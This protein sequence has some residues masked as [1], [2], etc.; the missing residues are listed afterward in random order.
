MVNVEDKV[1]LKSDA[2]IT[3]IVETIYNAGNGRQ[4]LVRVG[5]GS[6]HKIYEEDVTVITNPDIITIS[7]E[8]FQNAVCNV[9]DPKTYEGHFSDPNYPALLCA[10]GVIICE[11]LKKELFGETADNG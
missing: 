8:D 5:D 6:L 1:Q 3:G 2:S 4:L 10:C 7:K 11:Q 9:I